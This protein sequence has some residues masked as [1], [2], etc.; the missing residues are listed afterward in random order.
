MSKEFSNFL[1]E[2]GIMRQLS[3]EYTLQQN[4]V[5]KRANHTLVKMAKCI[6][7]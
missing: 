7:L 1:R 4:S 2:E 6:M 3:V 5:T